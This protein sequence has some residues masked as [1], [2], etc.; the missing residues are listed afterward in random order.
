MIFFLR[1]FVLPTFSTINRLYLCKI[2]EAWKREKG[3]GRS[4]NPKTESL[5]FTR[6]HWMNTH[7]SPQLIN[8][9]KILLV[10]LVENFSILT[11]SKLPWNHPL[12]YV[13][14]FPS[15]THL[16]ILSLSLCQLCW[17]A[18]V[19]I[20]WSF[21]EDSWKHYKHASLDLPYRSLFFS[22]LTLH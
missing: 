14:I 13:S 5:R 12:D 3:K 18:R 21:I 11:D 6:E 7:E 2:Q 4:S 22:L 10:P 17:L 20:L 8:S 9:G 15:K 1:L 19:F 16:I